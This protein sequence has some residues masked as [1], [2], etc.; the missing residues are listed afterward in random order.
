MKLTDLEK[1]MLDG[2]HGKGVQKAM[3]LNLRYAEALGAEEF[4]E[5]ASAGGYLIDR[6]ITPRCVP[7]SPELDIPFQEML[8][9]HYLDS[10]EV[11]EIPHVCVPSFHVETCIDE[12]YYA[13]QGYAEAHRDRYRNNLK[14][15][16]DIGVQLLC[17]C[18]PYLAGRVPVL[19]QHVCW[20]ESSAVV[21]IN[22]I[23]GA[24]TNCEGNQS[25][26][27]AML[28]GRTPN[29]GYHLDE[30]RLGTHL[31][32]VETDVNDMKEWGLLGYF[33]GK[34]VADKVPVIDGI[35]SVPELDMLKNFGAAAASSGGV[36][37]YHIPGLTAEMHTVEQAF[38]G[39]KPAAEVVYGKA[40][41]DAA[42]EQLN[43]T[44]RSQD[45]DFVMVGCP[46]CSIDQL[47]ELAILLDGKRV[48]DHVNMWVF[49]SE[50]V[51]HAAERCGYTQIIERAG[52]KV[53]IDTCP[54]LGQFVPKGTTSMVTNSAKQAH[55]L[56][57]FKGIGAWYGDIHDCVNAAVSGKWR[58]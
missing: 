37:L 33:A 15:L 23:Y 38:G 35:R 46:H 6:N 26:F 47:R 16:A 52:A 58:G 10:D 57:N 27:A 40:E 11:V 44:V 2:A 29:W 39:R 7:G 25:A 12:R 19:G 50:S 22:S 43:C 54:A 1:A 5:V 45:V 31:I 34:L 32:R 24:R 3:E 55:Y 18:T 28:T 30:N 49:A 42:Y 14:F 36:E 17:T 20:M 53:M 51:R 56:P 41:R 48:S 13:E 21:Y 8:S 9:T 4:V